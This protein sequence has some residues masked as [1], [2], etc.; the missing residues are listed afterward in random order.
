[1]L[2]TSQR[3]KCCGQNIVQLVSNKISEISLKLYCASFNDMSTTGHAS[4]RN[5]FRSTAGIHQQ[6]SV[7]SRFAC[8]MDYHVWGAMLEAYHKLRPK[9]KSITEL[10]VLLV[11]WDSLPQEPIN[12]AVHTVTEE[13]HKS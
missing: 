11:V 6:R 13:M 3:R 1:M 7:A 5:G 9:S 8:T 10:E 12:K 2:L 4:H